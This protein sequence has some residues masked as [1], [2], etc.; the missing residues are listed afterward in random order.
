V[1]APE[2]IVQAQTE[3]L[4]RRVAREQESLCRKAVDAAQE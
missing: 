3:A 4:L 1:S 2:S